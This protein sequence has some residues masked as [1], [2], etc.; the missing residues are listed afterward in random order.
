M[1]SPVLT[2]PLWRAGPT[3]RRSL[4][5][6][7][8]FAKFQPIQ[9]YRPRPRSNGARLG[10]KLQPCEPTFRLSR[11]SGRI[12]EAQLMRSLRY[13][14]GLALIAAASGASRALGVAVL[15]PDLPRLTGG[16][17]D[18][19]P[20]PG[21]T[22]G[23]HRGWAV[24][25][26]FEFEESVLDLWRLRVDELQGFW[27]REWRSR[28]FGPNRNAALWMVLPMLWLPSTVHV[29]VDEKSE[30]PE[31]DRESGVLSNEYVRHWDRRRAVVRERTRLTE[32]WLTESW[33]ALWCLHPANNAVVTTALRLKYQ[34]HTLLSLSD[35]WV[36]IDP[37]GV[38]LEATLSC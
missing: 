15:L 30:D 38:A 19:F 5:L 9:R 33:V 11:R 3:V 21:L 29:Q 23:A 1:S 35:G 8:R 22:Q 20:T 6:S 14:L 17:I 31:F 4:R 36:G 16:R 13:C 7:V 28:G 10:S 12:L 27:G 2:A 25:T 18:S 37:S 26:A 34:V 32:Q 24:R